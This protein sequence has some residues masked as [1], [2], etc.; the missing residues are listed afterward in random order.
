M[1]TVE[2][3]VVCQP[4]SGEAI[5]GDSIGL[6]RDA[7]TT[8]VAVVDGLGSGQAAAR[9]AQ[10]ALTCVEMNRS[11]PLREIVA[12]CHGALQATRGVVMGLVRVEH[13]HDC[14]AFVGVGN[15]GFSA[16]STRPMR[17]VSRNGLL[18]H[19]LPTLREFRFDCT[20]G[21]LVALYSDGISSRFVLQGG[22]AALS[23]APPQELARRIVKRFA[24]DDDVAV[25]VLMMIGIADQSSLTLT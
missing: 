11:Q 4:K 2:T 10:A 25:A 21:D 7:A 8:L 16:A 20:P 12:C 22:V 14:L 15:V 6:W 3:G 23:W 24:M 13:Q 19:R 9:A 1:V 17:P 18:G 5:S